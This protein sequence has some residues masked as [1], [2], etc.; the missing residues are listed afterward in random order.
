MYILFYMLF[1]IVVEQ[2]IKVWE[3][4]GKAWEEYVYKQ[5]FVHTVFFYIMRK[6]TLEKQ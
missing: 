5:M 2:L 3:W 6:Q 4:F 1:G